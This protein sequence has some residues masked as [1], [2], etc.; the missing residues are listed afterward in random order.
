MSISTT[1]LADFRAKIAKRLDDAGMVFWSSQELRDLI[2]EALLTF[3]A[4]SG[5]TVKTKE[6][7]LEVG[8][9]K[10]DLGSDVVVGYSDG[11]LSEVLRL[12]LLEPGS[13][14]DQ[15]PSLPTMY[16][17][18]ILNTRRDWQEA[19]KL[20]VSYRTLDA[21]GI[22]IDLGL[23]HLLPI[24]VEWKPYARTRRRRLDREDQQGM[25]YTGVPNLGKPHSYSIQATNQMRLIPS[26][27]EVGEIEIFEIVESDSIP[28]AMRWAL[29]YGALAQLLATDG[30]MRDGQRAEYAKKRYEDAKMIAMGL[31]LY[32]NAFLNEKPL[33][34]TSL[35]DLS[36]QETQWRE[37]TGTP[38][39]V[40]GVGWNEI[41]VY[42]KLAGGASS[43]QLKLDVYVPE[44]DLS[45][46]LDLLWIGAE[47][48]K[49]I[50]D[51]VIH[52]A[53][54]KVSGAEFA[55]TMGAYEELLKAAAGYNNKLAVLLPKLSVGKEKARLEKRDRM[56][57]KTDGE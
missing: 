38:K 3:Q 46:D 51:F 27:D 37:T 19:T 7:E 52:L 45:G 47:Y 39:M 21:S 35:A 31:P 11:D 8:D 4:V 26:P 12:A 29:K 2:N 23:G 43:V 1:T 18:A 22:F 49:V 15:Y 42:P 48:E 10:R 16:S 14:V 17:S 36:S 13:Y 28:H 41:V 56:Q 57:E 50:E 55:A 54:F 5:Y 32:R 33:A 6:I 44:A 20:Q 34:I 40:V 24:H 53:M 30:Q 25:I 9:W